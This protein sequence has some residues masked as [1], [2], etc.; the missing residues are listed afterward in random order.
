MNH[1]LIA[2]AIKPFVVLGALTF[3]LFCRYLVIWFL[4]EGRLKRLLLRRV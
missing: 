4:P 3:L 2:M 1:W